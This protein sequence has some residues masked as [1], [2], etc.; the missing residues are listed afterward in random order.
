MTYP[1]NVSLSGGYPDGRTGAGAKNPPSLRRSEVYPLVFRQYYRD[2]CLPAPGWSL[3]SSRRTSWNAG[4]WMTRAL[5]WLTGTPSSARSRTRSTQMSASPSQYRVSGPGSFC[6]R[7]GNA[8]PGGG[9]HASQVRQGRQQLLAN[10]AD[11]GD[12]F[13]HQLAQRLIIAA[14][15]DSH[16]P[17]GDI[18]AELRLLEHC[19]HCLY[20]RTMFLAGFFPR[21]QYRAGQ[22]FS[23]L[24]GGCIAVPTVDERRVIRAAQHRHHV[25]KAVIQTE[26]TGR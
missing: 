15:E 19:R 8:C 14:L 18:L 20:T 5:S 10:V 24:E 6:P 9:E 21:I 1:V 23:T 26:P 12:Q 3:A 2:P 22:R 17:A 25:G 7:M 16:C 13:L 4:F 11:R